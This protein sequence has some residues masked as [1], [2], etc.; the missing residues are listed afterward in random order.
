MVD[1]AEDCA[2]TIVWQYTS[3][4]AEVLLAES[5]FGLY[6]T[7]FGV[8]QCSLVYT[9]RLPQYETTIGKISICKPRSICIS[10]KSLGVDVLATAC[11]G[12]AQKRIVEVS[13]AGHRLN[14]IIVP[15]TIPQLLST[16]NITDATSSLGTSQCTIEFQLRLGYCRTMA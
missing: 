5:R 13:Q 11:S 16:Q 4:Q 2:S 9:E 3:F 7:G 12:H 14:T 15:T 8:I 1:W 6:S 10:P